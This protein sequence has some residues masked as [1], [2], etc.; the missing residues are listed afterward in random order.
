MP[1]REELTGYIKVEGVQKFGFVNVEGFWNF[2][3]K[4]F[5]EKRKFGGN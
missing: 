3:N 2:E 1:N 4:S 5:W